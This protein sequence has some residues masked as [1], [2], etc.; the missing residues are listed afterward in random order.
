[1]TSL[2]PAGETIALLE[3][4]LPVCTSVTEETSV[5]GITMLKHSLYQPP[6]TPKLS[7]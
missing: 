3:E 7:S 2:T 6:G 5:S 1:M 4:L